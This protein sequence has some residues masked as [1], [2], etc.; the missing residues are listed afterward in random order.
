MFTNSSCA[1][2]LTCE[3]FP[4]FNFVITLLYSLVYP[5]YCIVFVT[6]QKSKFHYSFIL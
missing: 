1:A 6:S 5:E 4:F 3:H 2:L